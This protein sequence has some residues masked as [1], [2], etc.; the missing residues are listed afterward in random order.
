MASTLKP[1]L[2]RL[3]KFER[4]SSTHPDTSIKP[5]VDSRVKALIERLIPGDG[6]PGFR[7]CDRELAL[8]END[9]LKEIV[10]ASRKGAD[11]G[12]KDKYR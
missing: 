12:V 11:G 5:G 9:F 4:G 6:I 10:G 8:P 7:G 2:T 1:F 3:D